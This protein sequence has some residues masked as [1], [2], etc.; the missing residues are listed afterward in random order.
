MVDTKSKTHF[1]RFILKHGPEGR[2]WARDWGGNRHSR[3][4]NNRTWGGRVWVL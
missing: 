4:G 3:A 1:I 2:R